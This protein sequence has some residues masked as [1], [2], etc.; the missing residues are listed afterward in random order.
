MTEEQVLGE[1]LTEENTQSDPMAELVGEG[2]KYA[3]VEEAVTAL[4]KKA[5]HADKHIETLLQ[6]K[7]E[8]EARNETSSKVDAILAKLD[9]PQD[10]VGV[11]EP[12]R[13]EQESVDIAALVEQKLTE[14][15]TAKDKEAVASANKNM[16]WT[17]LTETLGSKEEAKAAV[18]KY[19]GDNS[20]RSAMLEQIGYSLPEDA[21]SLVLASTK[22]PT[23]FS[24]GSS[25]VSPQGTQKQVS[26]TERIKADPQ[27]F[28]KNPLS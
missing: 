10:P 17:K 25:I 15:L 14:R 5:D 19:V 8:L 3:S 27:Y 18:K 26:Y 22:Q 23:Q 13:T 1:T 7:R 21:L 12:A 24:E 16:F 28:V 2:K 9:N 20:S 6:E 4:A 11:S